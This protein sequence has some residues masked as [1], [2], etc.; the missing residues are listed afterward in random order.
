MKT[1]SPAPVWFKLLTGH[2][3]PHEWQKEL[4]EAASCRDRLIR[5]PTGLGKRR[6]YC[7]LEPASDL[8]R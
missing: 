4:M 2:A 8:N 1:D 3:A 6:V 7:R 5:I